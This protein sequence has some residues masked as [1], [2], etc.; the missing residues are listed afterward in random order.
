MAMPLSCLR[1][2]CLLTALVLGAGAQ[3]ASVAMTGHMGGKAL[4][5]I[6]GG[7]PKALAAGQSHQG[8]KVVSVQSDQT[9]IEVDGQ[10]D[11]ITL[12]GVPTIIMGQGGGGGGAREIVLMAGTGGHYFAQGAINGRSVRFVVDTGATSVA[13]G[14]EEARRLGIKF[15]NG[16]PIQMGTANGVVR[17]YRVNLRSVRIQN[18]EVFDVEASVVPMAMPVVLL[19]NSFLGR[20]QMNQTN[21]TLRLT[22]R[23]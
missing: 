10:R 9:V 17:A 16:T 18:V 2:T 22:R 3:A 15:E 6:N 19:G 4:L 20:F 13:M 21:E 8:V 1:V 11:T 5:V 14:A 7:A 23:Y 12:G